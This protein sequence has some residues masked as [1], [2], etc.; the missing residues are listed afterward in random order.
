[1]HPFLATLVKINEG[2]QKCICKTDLNVSCNHDPLIKKKKKKLYQPQKPFTSVLG[3]V[4]ISKVD[5]CAQIDLLTVQHVGQP[6]VSPEPAFCRQPVM[7]AVS[8]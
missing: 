3:N 2:L 4:V 1:M 7:K 5:A 6:V 8:Y